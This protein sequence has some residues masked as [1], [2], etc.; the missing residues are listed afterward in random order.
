MQVLKAIQDVLQFTQPLLL[1]EL[2]G[3]VGSY[4]TDTPE[5]GY[6]GAFIAGKSSFSPKRR[7]N[8]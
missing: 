8:N 1:R 3:W 5:P 7:N 2:M 6:R 4:L